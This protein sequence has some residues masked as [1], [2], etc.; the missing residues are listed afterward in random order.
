LNLKMTLLV[1]QKHLVQRGRPK[2]STTYEAAPA[3][4]FGQVVRATRLD[5]GISQEA[6]AHLAGVERSHMGKVERGEH[7]PNLGL[8]FKLATALNTAPSDLVNLTEVALKAA[9]SKE[10]SDDQSKK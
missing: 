4:A 2:G 9:A 6:L 8:I 10:Q 7:L 1:M 3:K 5:Q